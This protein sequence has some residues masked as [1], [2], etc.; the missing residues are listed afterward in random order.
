MKNLQVFLIIMI[1]SVLTVTSMGQNKYAI[2]VGGP[3]DKSHWRPSQ[4]NGGWFPQEYQDFF[5]TDIFLMHQLLIN[6]LDYPAENVKIIFD[7]GQDYSPPD[8]PGPYPTRYKKEHTYDPDITAPD[9]LACTYT[10]VKTM[11][12]NINTNENDFVFIYIFTHGRYPNG[13]QPVPY[14]ILCPQQLH[15]DY[16]Y[17]DSDYMYANEFADLVTNITAQKKVIWMQPCYSGGFKNY[18][19]NHLDRSPFIVNYACGALEEAFQSDDM[20]YCPGYGLQQIN[21]NEPPFFYLPPYYSGEWGIQCHHGEFSYHL[22]SALNGETPTIG[23]TEYFNM[24]INIPLSSAD[25]NPNDGIISVK[26]DYD[27]ANQ[28][29]SWKYH[30]VGEH[31]DYQESIVGLSNKTSLMYPNLVS[32]ITDLHVGLTNTGIYG[33]TSDVIVSGANNSLSFGANSKIY[34]LNT[35]KIRV[36]GGG[37]LT[38]GDGVKIYGNGQ[39]SVRIENG[40]INLGQN[41]LFSSRNDDQVFDGLHLSNYATPTQI[42]HATFH[43]AHLWNESSSLTINYTNFDHVATSEEDI[44][45][46]YSTAGNVTISHSTFDVASVYLINSNSQQNPNWLAFVQHCEFHGGGIYLLGYR[47]LKI[48]YNEIE[49]QNKIAIE[50]SYCGNGTSLNQSITHNEIYNSHTGLFLN[51]TFAEINNNNIHNN[52][53]G[54]YLGN[55][56]QISTLKGTSSLTQKIKDCVLEELYSTPQNF[57]STGSNERIIPN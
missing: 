28:Y 22:Y 15:N 9:H 44:Y 56:S 49:H 26:E 52:Y 55:H 39:N 2:L 51:N 23:E 45:G 47:K 43:R 17:D 18:F 25:N 35:A 31:L 50:T 46:V 20:I 5:W 41:V 29:Q 10:N 42:N 33:V 3:I 4:Y 21:E 13:D 19:N 1:I 24:P 6:K 30:D 36:Q 16:L 11:L 53:H 32:S 40:T 48:D 27:W 38:I 34:L 54:I 57:S 37:S 7:N 14:G 8:N 12:Q